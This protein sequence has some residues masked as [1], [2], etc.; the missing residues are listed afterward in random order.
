MLSVIRLKFV[1]SVIRLKLVL[2]V[3]SIV[4]ILVKLLKMAWDCATSFLVFQSV[5]LF[6]RYAFHILMVLRHLHLI[7]VGLGVPVIRRYR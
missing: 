1:L 2:S 3:I 6:E 7:L 4:I 5:C